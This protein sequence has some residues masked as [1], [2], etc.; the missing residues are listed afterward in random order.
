MSRKVQIVVL[1]SY[2][3]QEPIKHSMKFSIFEF[4]QFL[5]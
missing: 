3:K 2:R 5:K 4:F 1:Y